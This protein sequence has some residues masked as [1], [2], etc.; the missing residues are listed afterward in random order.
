LARRDYA[1]SLHGVGL[2]LG[3]A[4]GIDGEHLRR[5]KGADRAHRV[6]PCL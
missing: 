3:T 4:E 6:I 1:L 2:S 5:L